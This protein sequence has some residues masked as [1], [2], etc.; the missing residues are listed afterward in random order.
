MD[1]L[2][3]LSKQALSQIVATNTWPDG[4]SFRGIEGHPRMTE[5]LALSKQPARC[6]SLLLAD[7]GAPELKTVE[8]TYRPKVSPSK[9]VADLLAQQNR[10]L[11]Q[12][13]RLIDIHLQQHL[14]KGD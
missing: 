11:K 13:R 3:G 9:S 1:T 8:K 14:S 12:L 2:I 5:I 6:A 7:M 4:L 10:L